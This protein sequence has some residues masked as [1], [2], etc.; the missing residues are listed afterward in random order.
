MLLPE[1]KTHFSNLL[2]ALVLAAIPM[3][4]IAPGYY[5]GDIPLDVHSALF[6]PP[7]QE[8][9]PAGLEPAA[10]SM[11]ALHAN[12]LYP[13]Y[14]FLNDV[15]QSNDSMM[16]NPDE[17]FGTPFVALWR[18]R[19]LSPF[20]VPLYFLNLHDGLWAS[21]LL[22]LIVA[23]LCAYYAAR[24]FGLSPAMALFVGMAY[25]W[26]GAIFLWR[27]MPLSDAAPWLPLLLPCTEWL[28]RGQLR[29]W[30]AAALLLAFIGL[31]GDPETLAAAVIFMMLYVLAHCVRYQDWRH[32]RLAAAGVVLT[33]V[34]TLALIA[35]QLA[36]FIEYL[37]QAVPLAAPYRAEIGLT[38]LMALLTP[39]LF[40]P[41]RSDDMPVLYLLY[42]G[43]APVLLL[44]L[45][46]SLRRFVGNDMRRRVESLGL[47]A[48]AMLL[49]AILCGPFVSLTGLFN[50]LGPQHF[51]IVHPFALAFLAAAA[52][53]EWNILTPDECRATLRRLTKGLPLFWG[54][55][56]LIAALRIGYSGATAGQLLGAL[57]M[58]F[59]TGLSLLALL[60]VTLIRPGP[61]VT[62]IALCAIALGT[63][64]WIF[65]PV[66]PQTE[67]AL[68]FP[69]TSFV[70][71]LEKMDARIGGSQM[72]RQW[73]VAGNGIPQ[74]FNPAGVTL[75]RYQAFIERTQD[76]PLL[77][78]RAG[79]KALL[80]TKQDIREDFAAI[81]PLLNIQEVYPSGA[82][83]FRDLDA[84]PRTRM[85]Y[86]GR[87]VDH[88]DPALLNSR[89]P[90]LIEGR[91]L[92]EHDEG[93]VAATRITVPIKND[94]I[95]V[96]I[97]ET[98]PGVLLLADA[99]YPGW[100]AKI[101]GQAVPIFPVDGIFR[102]I[103]IGNGKH[104]VEFIYKPFSLRLG[105]GI[106]VLALAYVLLTFWRF[107]RAPG[108][109]DIPL[110]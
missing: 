31:G 73:P 49:L 50:Q 46:W 19:A 69:E 41:E 102:G 81:R 17:A 16:W 86:A 85:I 57:A 24:R 15:W 82:I 34:F 53:E 106:S 43:A 6:S 35:A 2:C 44:P 67:A 87:T 55:L 63:G 91:N 100:Q 29:A 83:L 42:G 12:R 78:R 38:D 88:F 26:S 30:S 70:A 90:P 32:F 71:S 61:R 33:V 27:A 54:I 96:Q 40:S 11:S 1:R 75:R 64:W 97:D 93:P 5:A 94:S 99:W 51:L 22:K 74:T 45:W 20:S 9:R 21:V 105:I 103:E 101:D 62:G 4:S 108:A 76:D 25:Q 89:Q 14:R 36:P 68:A 79:A 110:A 65:R 72:L 98:R 52:A 58:P 8:A 107:W 60:G 3:V 109:R 10:T 18:S 7:W 95:T 66:L 59:V 84:R 23:G 39:R 92:P 13:W 104:T 48:L 47:A 80:L 37:R 56:L 28:I 77:L